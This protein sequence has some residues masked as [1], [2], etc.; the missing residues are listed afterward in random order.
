MSDFIITATC[1]AGH[2]STIRYSGFT[3]EMAI[4]QAGLLDGSS[5]LYIYPPKEGDGGKIGRCQWAEPGQKPCGKWF[6]CTIEEVQN[7]KSV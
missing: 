2:K 1:S 3:L 7:G 6:K 4:V 5:P